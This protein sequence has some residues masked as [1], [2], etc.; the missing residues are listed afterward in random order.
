MFIEHLVERPIAA[1]EHGDCPRADQEM[2]LAKR[3]IVELEAQVRS[4]VAVRKLLMR[5]HDVQP[6]GFLAFLPRATV[7][8]FHD[9][10]A[11]AGTDDE[12]PHSVAVR[13]V[14]AGEPRQLARNFIIRRFGL[15]SLGDPA[16]LV[17]GR[18]GDQG[19]GDCGLGNSRGSVKDEGGRDLRFLEKQ[20][21]FQQ[22]QL[23]TDGPE[24]LA[25]KEVHVLE[26][27]LVG[28]ALGLRDRRHLP[29]VLRLGLGTRKNALG[30]DR[31]SHIAAALAEPDYKPKSEGRWLGEPRKKSVRIRA[32]EARKFTKF[33]SPRVRARAPA[34]RA[35]GDDGRGEANLR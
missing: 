27:E 25:K 34:R 17:V 24:V 29:G 5:K 10:G 28:V 14:P 30:R 19:V 20:L 4:D 7:G 11:A 35:P 18:G 3:E 21:R 26:G 2:H 15:Q 12:M 32:A 23:E 31:V 13:F 1:G 9:R 6:D 33:V 8:A 22:L 16:L